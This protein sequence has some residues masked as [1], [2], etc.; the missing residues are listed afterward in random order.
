MLRR[1]S[2]GTRLW[3]IAMRCWDSTSLIQSY[4]LSQSILYQPCFIFRN[5][6]FSHIS[7]ILE[8]VSIFVSRCFHVYIYISIR[9]FHIFPYFLQMFPYCYIHII[10][11]MLCLHIFPD[12]SDFFFHRITGNQWSNRRRCVSSCMTSEPMPSAS[13]RRCG[14]AGIAGRYRDRIARS[15][16]GNSHGKYQYIYIYLK[17]H[18]SCFFIIRI[19]FLSMY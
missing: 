17:D 7:V 2:Q 9:C 3:P 5:S 15:L 18:L 19:F 13:Q 1:E 16:D 4:W 12:V 10:Y 14:I 8:Y 6:L 11:Y